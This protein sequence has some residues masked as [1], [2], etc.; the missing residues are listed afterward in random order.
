[1]KFEGRRREEALLVL[2]VS[3]RVCSPP[4]GEF[5]VLVTELEAGEKEGVSGIEGPS[6]MMFTKGEGR[7]KV[8]KVMGKGW[9]LRRVTSTLLGKR[10]KLGLRWGVRGG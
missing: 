10:L 9:M 5:D 6:V 7:M 3:E 1:L 4:L 8:G 2:R